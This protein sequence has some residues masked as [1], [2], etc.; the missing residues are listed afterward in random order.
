MC[1]NRN[2]IDMPAIRLFSYLW[3]TALIRYDWDIGLNKTRGTS[4]AGYEKRFMADC[5]GGN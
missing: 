3:K 4:K 2:L 1:I 5:F